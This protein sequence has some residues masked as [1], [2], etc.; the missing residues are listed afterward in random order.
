MVRKILYGGLLWCGLSGCSA[1]PVFAV[2]GMQ[3]GATCMNC[4]VSSY[5]VQALTQALTQAPTCY[6]MC[7]TCSR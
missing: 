3:V 7:A 6:G 1:V 2:P 5:R 4:G